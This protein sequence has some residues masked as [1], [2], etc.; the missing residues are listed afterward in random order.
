[1]TRT[2]MLGVAAASIVFLSSYGG[3]VSLAQWLI[4]GVAGFAV[5]NMVAE[6]GRGLQLGVNP[7]VAVV[8]ALVIA[9]L[10]ALVL[11]ALAARSTGIY[12]L[13]LTLTYAVIGFFFFGQVTTFSGFGGMTGIDPPAFFNDEPKRLYY[14]GVILSVL[15]YVAFRAIA[16]TPFGLSLQG[17]RDDPVRMS[18]LG[19]NIQLHRMLAFALAGFVAGTAGILNIWWNGQ[20]DPTS[21]SIGPTLDLLII[22]V[23]GGI[24]YFEGAWLGAFVFV[25]ANIYIRDLPGIGLLESLPL[26][27]NTLEDRVFAEAR[28]NTVIG[29]LL[30][31]I[32][33]LSRR[34]SW[35]SSCASRIGSAVS[36]TAANPT[37]AP[38]VR[39]Q[40]SKE[41]VRDRHGGPR[42]TSNRPQPTSNGGNTPMNPTRKKRLLSLLG[43]L[44]AFALLAAACGSDDD[45][46]SSSSDDAA[47]EEDEAAAEEEEPAAEE[48]EPAA[49][50]EE[51]AAEEEMDDEEAAAAD[52][53]DDGVIQLGIMGECEGAFGGWHEDVVAGTVLALINEA[54]ATSNS[55]TTA[56]DG[57]EGAEIAGV[58]IEL[59]GIGCGD[60]TADRAIQ[61]IRTLVEQNG[62][63][64][65]IGPLSGDE[66]VAIANY[67]LDHPEVT[68][69]NG[70]SGAQDST[71]HVRA[72]NFFRWNN[73][74]AQ[75]NAGIGDFLK[76]EAG[77]ET[78]AL[79]ADDYGFGWTSAAGFVADFCAAGG[80]VVTQVFPP[81]GETDYTSYV[82][83]LPD[84]DEV[85]GYF[86]VV[87]GTGTNASLEA[88]LNA[89][90][91]LTGD[92]HSGNLFFSPALAEAL[93]TDIAGAYVGGFASLPGDVST[94]AIEEY[95][96]SADAA[97]ESI[98]GNASGG[99]PAEP[100]LAASIGFMYGYYVNTLG[101]LTAL[102]AVDGDMSNN[103][104]ALRAAL[105]DLD[106]DAPYGAVSLDQ[107]RQAITDTF[108]AQLQLDEESGEIV[109]VTRAIIPAVDQTFGG[110]WSE[111]S[112][113]IE[114]DNTPCEPKDLPWHGEGAIPVV[115]GEPR[116][117]S[118]LTT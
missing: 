80:E 89:K 118:R 95:L 7:W 66:G 58:P 64:V 1:M 46:D 15:V 97:F 33:V 100:S 9:T 41:L 13:M 117:S 32:M 113:P 56:L 103:H 87:G 59:V 86:W 6:S 60:D 109:Q 116:A 62:A 19:F 52:G 3:M 45:D 36:A 61:E 22:A 24:G 31:L 75:W 57:F 2:M 43:I 72:P 54:G 5:G 114:R 67:A 44:F 99:E 21:I 111:D 85:D 39:S 79:I 34:A 47:A 71:L 68:F 107:N 40:R 83:Q 8:V 27:G 10:V 16:R 78:A 74:G 63:E 69:I 82:D 11:G 102:E 77:W 73:D 101:F 55:P 20:I 12:F 106:L 76:N 49:E 88:F 104:E 18:S 26:I 81:L 35:G 92:Q 23:I 65:V 98:S 93:G 17:V 105:S 53:D 50:E 48:E 42:G 37:P 51:P 110:T 96:A 91:E 108:V 30:L 29:L 94:P 28:F 84:P 25:G 4:F 90:G 70:S 38:K 14:A 112:P 115:D